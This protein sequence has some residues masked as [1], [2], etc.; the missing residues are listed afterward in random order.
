MN[1]AYV[2]QVH[3]W[4]SASAEEHIQESDGEGID[5]VILESWFSM[6][7]SILQASVSPG[8]RSRWASANWPESLRQHHTSSGPN[9]YRSRVNQRELEAPVSHLRSNLN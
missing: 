4:E 7:K 5:G 1:V 6:S 3:G 9:N 8:S 2:G